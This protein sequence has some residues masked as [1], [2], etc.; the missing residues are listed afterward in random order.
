[1]G[2]IFP[3]ADCKMNIFEAV[4]VP[5]TLAEITVFKHLNIPFPLLRALRPI[6]RCI[7]VLRVC[8]RTAGKGTQYLTR[9][10]HQLSG[11]RLRFIQDGFDLDLQYISPQIIV[12]ADP[13]VGSDAILHNPLKDVARFLNERHTNRYLL[14][15]VTEDRRYPLGPF[16]GRYFKFPIAQ[17]SVPS[18]D[19]LK[20]MVEAVDQWLK[21]DETRVVAVHSKHNQGRV[22]L[23]VVALMLHRRDHRSAGHALASFEALRRREASD[24]E[25]RPTLDSAS[26]L[27]FLD[28]FAHACS[29]HGGLPARTARIKRVQVSGVPNAHLLDPH[30]RLRTPGRGGARQLRGAGER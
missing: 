11:D 30:G 27:R 21:A 5:I 24:A 10:R 2:F 12:M 28:Y 13:T 7:R 3:M 26:Q 14:L 23:L 29:L 16:F 18:L 20:L 19:G 17:D 25:H 22:A 4:L 8:L 9:L 1:M 15:N 6:F